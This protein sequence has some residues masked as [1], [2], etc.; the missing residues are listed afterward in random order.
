MIKLNI[1]EQEY[2]SELFASSGYQV[3]LKSI[4]PELLRS[5]EQRVLTQGLD[6]PDSDRKLVHEKMR[7]EG[8]NKLVSA[9]QT[10]QR[11][12]EARNQS[13]RTKA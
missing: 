9:L 8:A 10:F 12:L 4:L 7:L 3:L 5:M 6:E 11:Q 2:I 1:D 13:P